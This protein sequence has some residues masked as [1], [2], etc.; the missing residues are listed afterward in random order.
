MISTT[1]KVEGLWLH[2]NPFSEVPEGGLAQATNVVIDRPSIA[3]VRRGQAQYGNAFS[4]VATSMFSYKGSLLVHVDN[5]LFY[6]AG[7]AAWIQY[8]GTFASPVNTRMRSIESNKN[9]YMTS[10]TG[11]LKLDRITGNVRSAGVPQGL[12]TTA[13]ISGNTGW[14][15]ANT[16][17]AYRI[18]WGYTDFNENLILGSPSGILSVANPGT[19]ATTTVLTFTIPEGI[20]TDHEYFIYRSPVSPNLDTPASD[21]L[22]L[23]IDAHPTANQIG[24]KS[25][26]VADAAPDDFKGAFIYTAPSQEGI[27][28]SNDQPPLAQDID[29]YRGFTFY[30]NVK[31]KQRLF[32]TL[33]SAGFPSL[34]VQGFA[35]ANTVITSPLIK[36]ISNTAG[37]VAGMRISSASFPVGTIL[38]SVNSGTQ[39]TANANASV[40]S[41]VATVTFNDVVTIANVNY[42][43]ANT[44]DATGTNTFFKVVA[45]GTPADNIEATVESLVRVLN[46][47]SSTSLVYAYYLSGFAD[48]PGKM[49]IQSR[50][51]GGNAFAVTSTRGS[52]FSPTLPANG[53]S[54]VSTNEEKINRISIS[55]FQ[56]PEAVPALNTIDVG[57]A[58]FP[59]TR[60]VALKESVIVWKDDGCFRITGTQISNFLTVLYDASAILRAPS[61]AVSFNNK[62]Y[63]FTDQGIVAVDESG[64]AIMSPAIELLLLELN[65]TLYPNF[66]SASFG[67]GYESDRKYIF[68]TVTDPTD[69]YATQAFVY[70]HITNTWTQWDTKRSTGLVNRADNKLYTCNQVS[71]QIYRE[72]KTFTSDDYADEEF[73]VTVL[74]IDSTGTELTLTDTTNLQLGM[75][76]KQSTSQ[77][78]ILAIDYVLNV[79]TVDE[80]KTWALGPAIV[81]SS[82]PVLLKFLPIFLNAPGV[83]KHF[84]EVTCLFNDALFRSIDIGFATNFSKSIDYTTINNSAFGGWGSFPWGSGP[85]GAGGSGGGGRTA[86]RTFVPIEKQRG[87]W[88]D[89]SIRSNEVFTPFGFQG[90][91]L[92]A[93][94]TGTRFV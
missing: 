12:D 91:S 41:N 51:V 10:N 5:T 87:H 3:E 24:Q 46:Q 1:L 56:Q 89:I 23:V 63:G 15:T 53:T 66:S 33:V 44:E 45:T 26:T 92:K 71:K 2:P 19:N 47:A 68:Y 4:G 62:V 11:L 58:N 84:E 94:L 29:I 25:I 34:S 85:W 43:A 6:D 88:I 48:L 42:V 70:N 80:S 67:V 93:D 61:S 18:V 81:Y 7:N 76:F 49:L 82:I 83:L 28:Q 40:T 69:T 30:A 73:P 36:N 59:I 38:L 52:S 22:Q 21:E 39:V 13:V 57:S 37:L 74:D 55:K 72:R 8:T 9:L 32:L 50:D 16:I 75:T 20:T 79:I 64:V 78:H 77:V 65:S 86:V 14:F 27:L 35:N 90:I 31:T 17:V 60:I 54:V